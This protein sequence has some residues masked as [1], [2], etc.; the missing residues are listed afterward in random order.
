MKIHQITDSHNQHIVAI[1]KGEELRCF[2]KHY[3]LHIAQVAFD[4]LRRDL[5]RHGESVV[6]FEKLPKIS[7]RTANSGRTVRDVAESE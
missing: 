4:N 7:S 3:S 5:A 6:E 1:E 2:F